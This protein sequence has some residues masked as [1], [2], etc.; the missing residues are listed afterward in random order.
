MIVRATQP[1]C[2]C[3]VRAIEQL[4]DDAIEIIEHGIGMFVHGC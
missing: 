4:V 1:H 3:R 2:S